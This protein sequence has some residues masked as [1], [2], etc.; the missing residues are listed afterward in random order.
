LSSGEYLSPGRIEHMLCQS[1]LVDNAM[2]I[3]EKQKYAS[4]LLFPNFQ[5]LKRIKKEQDMETVSDEEFFS[6]PYVKNEMNKL[7]ERINEK[8]NSWEKLVK[9]RFILETPTIENGEL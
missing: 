8:I 2:V 3:G 1:Q 9:Y 5:A 7:L 6:S 4:C